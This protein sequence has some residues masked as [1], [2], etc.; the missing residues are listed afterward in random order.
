MERAGRIN[1]EDDNGRC[2]VV[3]MK[4]CGSLYREH[5]MQNN[6]RR[7]CVVAAHHIDKYRIFITA[8]TMQHGRHRFGKGR[9][10]NRIL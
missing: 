9:G 1:E 3:E 10:N 8:R 2:W 6:D 5:T 4:I 7:L